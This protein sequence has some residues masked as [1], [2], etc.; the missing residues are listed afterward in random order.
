[1]SRFNPNHIIEPIL[2]A[3]EF[4]KNRALVSGD[5]VFDDSEVWSDQNIVQIETYFVNNLD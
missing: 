4:W 1:M 5:S 2:D 3:A